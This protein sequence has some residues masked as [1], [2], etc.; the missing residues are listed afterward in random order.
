MKSKQLFVIA[1]V[2]LGIGVGSVAIPNFLRARNTPSSNACI[3]NLRQLD[4]AVQQWTLESRKQPGDA[5][6]LKDITPYLAHEVHCQEG[7]KYAVGPAV[8]NG[9]RCSFPG[10]ELPK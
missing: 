4:G 6:I 2:A 10:H 9:V 1:V 3:N 5:V 8:S 7:G